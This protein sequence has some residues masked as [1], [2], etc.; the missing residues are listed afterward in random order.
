MSHRFTPDELQAAYDAFREATSE[1]VNEEDNL[2]LI[3]NTFDDLVGHMS[4]SFFIR[5]EV[6]IADALWSHVNGHAGRTGF[7]MLKDAADGQTSMPHDEWLDLVVTVGQHRRS[8]IRDLNRSDIERMLA[9][10]VAN[11]QA[12][13]LA[14]AVAERGAAALFSALESAGS[15]PDALDAGSFAMTF[16]EPSTATEGD[17]A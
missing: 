11:A 1:H 3:R 15:I 5:R 10:R 14:L 4:G 6:L 8:L 16:A 17:A 2:G 12:A 7:Q 13:A 9:A